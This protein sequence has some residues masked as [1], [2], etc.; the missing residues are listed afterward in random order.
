MNA[1]QLEVV[2]QRYLDREMSPSEE[3]ALLAELSDDARSELLATRMALNALES[4]PR[5]PAPAD[6]SH[7]VMAALPPKSKSLFTRLREWLENRP[8]LGWEFGGAAV[9]ASLLFFVF[10]PLSMAPLP[11]GLAQAPA[12]IPVSHAPASGRSAVQLSLYSPQ[13]HSVSLIGDF[14]GWGS[15]EEIKLAPS[16]KGMWT[17][18]LPLPAGRYQYAFLVDGQ[19]WV[20]DP[21][22]EQH[23]NDDFGRRNAV[24]TII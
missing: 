15:K 13:A 7:K 4:L 22:A 5:M 23:V 24:V 10:S 17:V 6:L 19:R 16:G 12:F 21:Q 9:A 8:L 20:T 18:T 11:G 3:A 2:S 14:N 1:P